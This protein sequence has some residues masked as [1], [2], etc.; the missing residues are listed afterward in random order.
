M[1]IKHAH[2]TS[3][4]L[5]F[6]ATN[7]D[8]NQSFMKSFLNYNCCHNS[9]LRRGSL[10][11]YLW[12]QSNS[13]MNLCEMHWKHNKTSDRRLLQVCK[14]SRKW[15][16]SQFCSSTHMAI[17]VRFFVWGVMR[18]DILRGQS[19]IGTLQR[20]SFQI[21]KFLLVLPSRIA[22]D[23]FASNILKRTFLAN[24]D[25]D[26]VLLGWRDILAMLQV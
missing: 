21:R 18:W 6:V 1:D 2:W 8:N 26:C 13:S 5:F 17:R 19:H 9:H 16:P 10:F 25:V 12:T 24:T 20:N 23:L 22:S 15:N 3:K 4:P 7:I 11:D 14:V